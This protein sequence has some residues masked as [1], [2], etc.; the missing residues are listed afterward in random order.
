MN[1]SLSIII[2][3]RNEEKYIEKIVQRVSAVSFPCEYELVFVE[4]HSKD[5]TLDEIKRVVQEYRDKMNIR[6]ATQ[7]G[8]GKAD[9]IWKGF[10]IANNDILMIL[11]ADLTVQPEDL[12][13]FYQAAA[14]SSDIFVNGSRLVCP[15]ENGA[16][17]PLN[18]LGNKFFAIL[19]SLITHQKMTDTLCGTKV[20]YKSQFQK[21]KDSGL[22]EKLPDPFCDFTLILGA[23]RL[24][25]KIVEVPVA[26][27]KRIYDGTKIRRF[28]DGWKLLKICFK[29]SLY[30]F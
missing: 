13:K 19:L 30:A 8:I 21:I 20:I 16:M 18:Y 26:Y 12:P 3:A 11:D 2:P 9:A 15:M 10:G 24:G 5:K 7:D 27:K 17:R 25:L 6:Y 22:I 1:S 29:Y 28:R 4:G 23:K 14:V